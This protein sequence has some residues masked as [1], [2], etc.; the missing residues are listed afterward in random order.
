MNEEVILSAIGSTE[1][2]TFSEFC[3]ALGGD[4][5]ESGGREGWREVFNHLRILERHGFVEISRSG[6]KIDSMVLTE[7]G[8]NRIREKLDNQRGLLTMLRQ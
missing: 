5:P 7:A 3:S 8:A 2:T 4:C 6:N 1:E